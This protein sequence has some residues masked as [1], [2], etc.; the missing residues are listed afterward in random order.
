MGA[1]AVEAVIDVR[2]ASTA[3]LDEYD[4]IVIEPEAYPEITDRVKNLQHCVPFTWVKECLISGR[5]LPM[6]SL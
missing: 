4:Y 1:T 2:Y 6:D 3:R 5:L